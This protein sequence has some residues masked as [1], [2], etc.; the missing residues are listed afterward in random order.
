MVYI[1]SELPMARKKEKIIELAKSLVE[2]SDIIDIPE[3]P[4]G[5]SSPSSP[6]LSCIIKESIKEA[7]I[8]THLRLY[9]INRLALINTIMGLRIS[10]INDV[11]LLRGDQPKIGRKVEEITPDEGI[12]LLRQHFKRLNVG[13]L[14]N[15]NKDLKEIEERIK[16]RASFYLITRPWYSKKLGS[17]SRMIRKNNSKLY[18]YFVIL[19]EK[20]RE[21][22]SRLI[23]KEEIVKIEELE[24]RIEVVK[25]YIDGI[26]FSSPKDYHSLL[27]SLKIAGKIL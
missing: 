24:E 3:A 17:V 22:L 15:L 23:P 10:G 13:L 20:N 8:I 18:I 16:L 4:L 27:T 21:F 5:F 7:N 6:I 25:E 9:D 1:I 11:L 14:I 12:P 26:V 2:F 19:T